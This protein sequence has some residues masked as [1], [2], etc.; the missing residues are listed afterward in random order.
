SPPLSEDVPKIKS[1]LLIHHGE[2]D[3]RL[4]ASLP[5]YEAAL[6]TANVNYQAFIYAGAQHGF[7]NDT[8]PRYDEISAKLAWKRTVEFF[9]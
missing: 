6:K 9:D 2:K 8:T 4:I 5:A 1:P 3:E 7:N